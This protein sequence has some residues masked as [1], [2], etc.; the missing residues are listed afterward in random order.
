MI[1]EL[2]F[3]R[4]Q[5]CSSKYLLQNSSHE[6]K[7]ILCPRLRQSKLQTYGI[8]SPGGHFKNGH[9]FRINF[10]SSP[11][12]T[13]VSLMQGVRPFTKDWPIFCSQPGLTASKARSTLCPKYCTCPCT[14]QAFPISRYRVCHFL[15]PTLL[16]NNIS[17]PL[18]NT[19]ENLECQHKHSLK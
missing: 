9:V 3:N 2:K 17:F 14:Y 11:N 5:F 6:S 12:T 16:C 8:R 10:A 4:S 18:S 19:E 13:R 1:R 7:A 15:F